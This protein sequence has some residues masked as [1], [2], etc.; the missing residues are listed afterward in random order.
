MTTT[1]QHG[2]FYFIDLR[3]NS[4]GGYYLVF[5]PDDMSIIDQRHIQVIWDWSDHYLPTMWVMELFDHGLLSVTHGMHPFHLT[6]VVED[7]D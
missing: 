6:T 2:P 4:G 7:E 5:T 3:R 1:E